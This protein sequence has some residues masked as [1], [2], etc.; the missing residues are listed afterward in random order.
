MDL[1]ISTIQHQELLMR[2]I[3]FI[4]FSPLLAALAISAR[5]APASGSASLVILNA[6]VF[7]AD[8]TRSRAQAVA[9]ENGLNSAVGST[10]RAVRLPTRGLPR[11]RSFLASS[12]PSA[13]AL[14]AALLAQPVL[15]ANPGPFSL[16]DGILPGLNTLEFTTR[17]TLSPTGLR[18][19]LTTTAVP[20][21]SAWLLMAAGFGVLALRRRGAAQ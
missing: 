18:V 3:V 11:Q 14:A 10:G 17:S 1:A 12:L 13:L 9:V 19:E 4:A 5:A 2:S 20:E 21:P 7:T 15:A 6:Q 16:S 8:E